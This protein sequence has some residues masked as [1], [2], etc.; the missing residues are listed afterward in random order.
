[1]KNRLI[2]NKIIPYLNSSEVIVV[3]GAR[4]VGK[5]TLLKLIERHIL[6]EDESKRVVYLDLED[7]FNLT[8]CNEG[9]KS[10]LEYIR[11]RYSIEGHFV[12]MI[13]EIQYLDNPSSF[14]KLIH[15]HH[16]ED[17]KC[18]VS[19]SS[20]FDIKSKFKDN[21]VGRTIN[22]ELFPLSFAE[23]LDFK[24][25]RFNLSN[26][27]S[28]H[29][30]GLLK[31]HYINFA[32]FGGYPKI[33]LENEIQKKEAFLKQ[34]ITTY[35]KKD[36]VDLGKIKEIQKYNNLIHIL[37]TQM[38]DQ[39]NNLEVS[40]TLDLSRQTVNHYIDVMHQTYVINLVF[41]YSKNIRTELSKMP[42]LFWE[43]TGIGTLIKFSHFIEF[44][45]GKM[46]ENSVYTELR[47]GLFIDKVNYWRTTNK[48][49]VDFILQIKNKV[50]PLEVKLNYSG[51]AV[52]SL[53]YFMEKYNVD[54]GYIVT[55]NKNNNPK[56]DNIV[57][58]YP[59]ELQNI[60][61]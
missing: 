36:L 41:P 54:V 47:K 21:L 16:R 8:L 35:V 7:S 37:A 53:N 60:Q 14:L 49:E 48:Q 20:S 27:K 46:F 59:W 61:S 55:L 32:K 43:D 51:Q 11:S 42:K 44:L 18:L 40:N 26:I 33:V 13:D 45:D 10:V 29:V 24:D 58:L 25:E 52:S 1:M 19:G 39:L 57:L 2:L 12:L 56:S 9:P 30:N 5:T 6:I 31:K 3:H 22:F 28:E 50:V 15:D 38:T 17:L 23:Y 4:Q 34:I